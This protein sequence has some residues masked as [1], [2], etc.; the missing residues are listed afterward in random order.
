MILTALAAALEDFDW[1]AN[2]ETLGAL[3][4]PLHKLHMLP[5][6]YGICEDV[7]VHNHADGWEN[8]KPEEERE[9]VAVDGNAA[10]HC[11]DQEYD[12]DGDLNSIKIYVSFFLEGQGV[13]IVGKQSKYRNDCNTDLVRNAA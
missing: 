6:E 9:Q 2:F 10:Q 3:L 5:V 1:L 12:H 7:N 4:K 13:D 11:F 8:I